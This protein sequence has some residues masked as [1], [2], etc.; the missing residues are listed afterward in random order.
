MQNEVN[1][2]SGTTE[3]NTSGVTQ[4]SANLETESVIQGKK[5]DE[6]SYETHRKLLSEKK[7]LS[8]QFSQTQEEL[9]KLREE[10]MMA[11]GK[12]DEL[13][14]TLKKDLNE[15]KD[16]FKKQSANYAFKT[17]SSQV[18]AEAAT[19]G[20]RDVE[21]LIQL[22][23]LTSLEIGD[24]FS[25]DKEQVKNMLESV[26]EQRSW[27][28]DKPAPNVQTGTPAKPNLEGKTLNDLSLDEKLRLL[29]K[30]INE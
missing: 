9:N 1:S 8:Q 10:R 13:I 22:S 20:C 6:V 23:D 18:A 25:I 12:K 4:D 5:A 24:D 27:L 16:R 15:T 2:S 11:E 28:F 3:E 14:A 21:A 30:K 7:K 26:K 19:M 29:S 17:V